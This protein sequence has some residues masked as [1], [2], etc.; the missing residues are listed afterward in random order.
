[1]GDRPENESGPHLPPNNDETVAPGAIDKGLDGHRRGA[2]GAG[3]TADRLRAEAAEAV[4]KL[5]GLSPREREVL[6]LIAQGLSIKEMASSLAVSPKSVETYRARL[7][8]KLDAKTPI[9]LMRIAV[10]VSLMTP[11]ESDG[12]DD[13]PP[14]GAF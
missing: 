1:M 8:E 5:A 4:A 9:A 12:P 3:G 7:L 2:A 6:D 14:P 11:P 13:E 10:L